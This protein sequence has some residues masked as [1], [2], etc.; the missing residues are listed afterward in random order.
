MSFKFLHV[1]PTSI[2]SSQPHLL[3]RH[4][5][6]MTTHPYLVNNI[7]E[8]SIMSWSKISRTEEMPFSVAE[9]MSMGARKFQFSSGLWHALF[10]Q[11]T[12]L[13]RLHFLSRETIYILQGS[14][15]K[16]HICENNLEMF[17]TSTIPLLGYRLF[18][19]STWADWVPSQWNICRLYPRCVRCQG[20][21]SNKQQLTGSSQS[22]L[23]NHI[24]ETWWL[25][26]LGLKKQY[27]K[28]KASGK[29]FFFWPLPALL[30]LA[31]QL[32]PRG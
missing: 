29:K 2:S 12:F 4:V 6:C 32:L 9:K 8:P 1:V 27:P 18:F 25:P 30:S 19:L 17:Y 7:L 21:C 24:V 10:E 26:V 3:W 16:Q 22:K 31:P 5:L 14:G 28:R 20:V 23:I 11:V 13:L 15:D